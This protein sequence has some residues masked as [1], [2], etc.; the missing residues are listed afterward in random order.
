MEETRGVELVKSPESSTFGYR[1]RSQSSFEILPEE[2]YFWSYHEGT[3][4]T[5]A[6]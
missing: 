6:Y 1:H 2:D 4:K 5:T 3:G